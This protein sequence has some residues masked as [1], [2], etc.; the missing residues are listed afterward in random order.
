MIAQP[1]TVTDTAPA[2]EGLYVYCV[3]RGD[4]NRLLGPIGLG[5]RTV[6]TLG[7]G[8]IRAVV[9]DCQAEPY[10]SQDPQVVQ[11]WV[12]AHQN[13]VLAAA[14]ALSRWWAVCGSRTIARR[15][16]SVSGTPGMSLSPFQIT[17][18][19]RDVGPSSGHIPAAGF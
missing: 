3:A 17:P 4:G 8:D 19:P 9:H 7:S 18:A 5:G 10:Q 6:Y 13:V 14:Q 1:D 16:S 11:G 15:A 2:G 12:V